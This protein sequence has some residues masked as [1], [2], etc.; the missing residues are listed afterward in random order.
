LLVIVIALDFSKAFDAAKHNVLLSKM[1][2][3]NI[4]DPSYNWLV[5]FITDRKHC[6]IFQG[7]TSEV[8]DVSAS[9]IQ[10]SA[11]G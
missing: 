2:M 11:V 7:L 8:L 3:L 9:I 4:P 5:D 10:G 1:A 6:M